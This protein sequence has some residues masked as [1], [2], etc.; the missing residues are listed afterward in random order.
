MDG[1]GDYSYIGVSWREREKS[2][3][4]LRFFQYKVH[5]FFCPYVRFSHESQCQTHD[6]SGPFCKAINK[7][8]TLK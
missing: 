7:L 3:A 6:G 5:P 1:G 2:I 4:G 8:M